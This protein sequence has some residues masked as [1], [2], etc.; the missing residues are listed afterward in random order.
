MI[1]QG[2]IAG[3]A[4]GE[5]RRLVAERGGKVVDVVAIDRDT[6]EPPLTERII[7]DRIVTERRERWLGANP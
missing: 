5:W 1:S 7:A 6:I 3:D 2:S 4:I